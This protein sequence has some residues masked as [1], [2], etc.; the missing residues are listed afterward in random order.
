MVR[1]L[2]LLLAAGLLI[3][4]VAGLDDHATAW[5]TWLAGFG[6]LAG[7]MIAAGPGVGPGHA[8]KPGAFVVLALGLVVLA[9]I[10]FVRHAELWL[11]SCVLFFACGF[12]FV[13]VAGSLSGKEIA[14]TTMRSV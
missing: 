14:R 6:A 7:F 13:G 3:L 11:S 2:S 9:T 5:L 1:G 8:V 12:L 10:G 4:W